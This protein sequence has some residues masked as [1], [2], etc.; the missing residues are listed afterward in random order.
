MAVS[1]CAR[2]PQLAQ[3]V[4]KRIDW[5]RAEVGIKQVR[6]TGL[7]DVGA[8]CAMQYGPR[9]LVKI[10]PALNGTTGVQFYVLTHSLGRK[11]AYC[12]AAEAIGERSQRRLLPSAHGGHRSTNVSTSALGVLP[13]PISELP[14]AV[15]TKFE[16][17]SIRGLRWSLITRVRIK[18]MNP[19]LREKGWLSFLYFGA[20][21]STMRSLGRSTSAPPQTHT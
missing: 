1:N 12:T 16:G 18:T 8:D 17:G 5:T 6:S 11:P 21:P 4:S 13:V 10:F 2:V 7:A 15:A 14:I 3:G 9:G 20:K 19:R